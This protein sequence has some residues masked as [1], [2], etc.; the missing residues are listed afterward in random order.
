MGACRQSD[1][2]RGGSRRHAL[3]RSVTP[4]GTDHWSDQLRP[5]PQRRLQ[6]CRSAYPGKRHQTRRL[7]RVDS[8]SPKGK[9]PIADSI[10]LVAETLKSREQET[11]IVFV[12]DGEETC[13]DDPCGVVKALKQ[14]GI[15]FKLHVVGFDVN[16]MQKEQL[17]CLA[18]AGDGNYYG[19]SDASTLLAAFETVTETVEEKVEEIKIEK[20][21]ATKKKAATK[22]GKLH[23]LFPESGTRSLS[24]IELKRKSDGK[25]IKSI[26]KPKADSMHPLLAGEYD[27]V[28]WFANANYAPPTEVP[29]G[30]VTI[31]GGET[32]EFKLGAVTFNIAAGITKLPTE[33]VSVID[34]ESGKPFVT[35]HSHGNGYFLY[36]AKPVPAGTYDI[37]FH[38]GRSPEPTIVA[39]NI[40]VAEG[41][42]GVVSLDSGI[43][44]K[45][46]E[47]QDITGW[48]VVRPDDEKSILQVRRG[49]DNQFPLWHNF[50]VPAG[51][52]NVNIHLRGMDDPLPVG[53]GVEIATGDLLEFDTGL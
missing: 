32:L 40:V 53:E 44:L 16:A 42:A 22:L 8:I 33:A 36:T 24:H 23:I 15:K 25:V 26:K 19:A 47:G 14:S 21:K 18:S 52:Y 43:R 37:A 51:T 48:D 34:A 20:A 1:K 28:L 49:R 38:Y 27:V 50:V 29:L 35:I 3:A 41:A 9:T 45:K 5:S 30:T 31:V 12:S 6:R 4:S 2:D 7:A 13:N 11:T 10:T 17:E 46:P 39:E